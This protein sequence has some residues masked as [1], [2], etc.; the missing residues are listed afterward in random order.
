MINKKNKIEKLISELCP[1][2]V[3]F[4]EFGKLCNS[5]RKGTLKTGELSDKGKYPVINSG[6]SWYGR[7]DEYNNNGD[8][9]AIAAR[10]EYAGFINY[11]DE[12]FWAGG[13]CYPY[14]SKDKNTAITKFIFYYL[15]EKQ[16]Y[17]RETLVARGSIPAI[18]KSDVDKIKIP[19]PPLPI[20]QEIVKILDNFTELEAE[21]EAELGARKKQYECYRDDMLNFGDEVE[22]KELHEVF[23]IKNGYTPSKANREYWTNG[24]VPWFR[25][26]DIRLNG[27]VLSDSIQHVSINAVKR[28]GL[29]P[30]NSIIISTT[31]TIGEHAIIT[32]PFLINQ[33]LTAISTNKKYVN[34]INPKFVFYYS[35]IIGK[36]CKSSVSS[37]GFA[38]INTTKFKKFK[39]P[40][41]PLSEQERIVSILDKFDALVNDISIGL[42]AELKA[43]RQQYEYYRNKLLTFP[44]YAKK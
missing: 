22:F 40:I 14:S 38:I 30:A 27:R 3:E 12:K 34:K 9:I 32:K 7:Y 43:R 39:I 28:G 33:Q 10:G 36:M 35:W 29:L 37:G 2:G 19:V 23:D 24:T 8:S 15:K 26:E 13:L 21:L 5:L 42:P 18:N 25:M 4:F 11:I 44:E 41:P 17:I 1:D 16:E 20:Q 6:R 31:A